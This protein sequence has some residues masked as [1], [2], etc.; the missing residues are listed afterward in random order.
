MTERAQSGD[1]GGPGAS[2]LR[3]SSSETSSRTKSIVQGSKIDRRRSRY[4]TRRAEQDITQMPLE[5]GVAAEGADEA[6]AW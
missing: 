3:K 4:E 6:L 5:R 1:D 2:A